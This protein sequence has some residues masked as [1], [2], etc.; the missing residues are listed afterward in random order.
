MTGVSAGTC[1]ITAVSESG[2]TSDTVEVTVVARATSSSS[3]TGSVNGLTEEQADVF[4]AN[5]AKHKANADKIR[6]DA[7]RAGY[8]A[9]GS[10]NT[11]K[12]TSS[13]SGDTSSGS[14]AVTSDEGVSS[15]GGGIETSGTRPENSQSTGD[16]SHLPLWTLVSGS[17]AAAVFALYRSLR[18]DKSLAG[19]EGCG[20]DSHTREN[21]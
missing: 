2:K 17:L 5:A 10:G 9:D 19:I 20:E 21:N 4:K 12:S 16:G 3:T 14:S 1:T 18:R 8:V 15:E 13:A 11:T 6:A 7:I